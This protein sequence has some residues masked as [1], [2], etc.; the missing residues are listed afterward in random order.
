[1]GTAE[2]AIGQLPPELTEQ[3]RPAYPVLRQL[4][5]A[6]VEDS[7][8][9]LAIDDVMVGLYYRLDRVP[10][11]TTVTQALYQAVKDGHLVRPSRGHYALSAEGREWLERLTSV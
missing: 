3:L 8:S 6:F 5:K 1:M 11:R 2:E 7:R 10:M 4:L 9:S